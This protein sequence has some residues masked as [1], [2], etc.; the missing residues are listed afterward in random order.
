[1][2][3]E[4][5]PI[6]RDER[7][8]AEAREWHIN[9]GYPKRWF[10]ALPMKK[11]W[12]VVGKY[13]CTQIA[14]ETFSRSQGLIRGSR[15]VLLSDY[16]ATQILKLPVV[17]T[18]VYMEPPVTSDD[19]APPPA[20]LFT[21]FIPSRAFPHSTGATTEDGPRYIYLSEFAGEPRLLLPHIRPD[22]LRGKRV[23]K[24]GLAKS[25]EDRFTS[26][27]QGFPKEAQLHGFKWKAGVQSAT[28]YPNYETAVV[29]EDRLKQALHGRTDVAI[30]LGGEFFLANLKAAEEIF[31]GVTITSDHTIGSS[32]AVRKRSKSL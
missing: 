25:P 5:K 29:V 1:M 20:P 32:S 10:Y 23:I 4:K 12:K 13:D 17:P 26:L 15:G 18:N 28:Q 27:N 11:A 8:T 9:N 21:F 6:A 16:E 14:A 22:D 2:Q 24:V 3:V 19:E 7:L 30:S 31:Y